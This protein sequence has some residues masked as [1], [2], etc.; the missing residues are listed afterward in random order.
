MAKINNFLAEYEDAIRVTKIPIGEGMPPKVVIRRFVRLLKSVD[1]K[2]MQGMIDYPLVEIILIAFLAVLGGAS[3]WTEMEM[4]GKAK[5]FWLRKFIP[6]KNGSPSHDTFRRVFALIDTKQL[7]DVTIAFLLENVAA[8]KRSLGIKEDGIR[9][10]CVDGKEQRGTGRKYQY[11]EEKIR[12]LQTLHVYDASNAICLY[13]EAIDIKTNEI[14]VAQK[15]LKGMTLKGCIVTF[16]AMHMQRDTIGIIK[17]AKGEYVG[18]LKGNQSGLQEEAAAYFNEPDLLEHYKNK[19][20]YYMTQEK[21]HSQIETREFYLVRP[22]KRKIIKDWKGLKAFVCYIKR[23]VSTINGKEKIEIRYYAASVED[24]ELCAKAI[25]GH[26]SVENLLHWHLDVSLNED[27]NTTMDKAAFNNYSLLNKM[28][29]SLYKLAKP[30]LGAPSIRSLR[31]MF[32]WGY[33]ESI[34][35]VLSSF[36]EDTLAKA[37]AEVKV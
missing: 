13:S 25:R 17:N 32:G 12:N 37:M 5:I 26:W 23:T 33:E 3:S 27:D 20:D 28:V 1:D 29:L 18:G 35:A 16:D 14:P 31:K 9:H 24:V 21:A 19:G 4:F 7:Q 30:I 8:I 2:R 11:D 36:D 15:I 10:I 22:M 6:M 34:T